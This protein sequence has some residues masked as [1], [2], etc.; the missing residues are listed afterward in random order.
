M[1]VD[2]DPERAGSRDRVIRA[3]VAAF[4]ARH[5]MLV[6]AG[7]ADASGGLADPQA[8]VVLI[9]NDPPPTGHDLSP[10]MRQEAVDWWTAVQDEVQP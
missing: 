9:V 4:V 5:G 7:I 6:A 3:G 2:D 1:S 10:G 8:E